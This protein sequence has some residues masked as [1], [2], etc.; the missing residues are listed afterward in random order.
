MEGIHH[1][2]LNLCSVDD[3]QALGNQKL[4]ELTSLDLRHITEL[5]NET[6]M[7]VVKR[8]RNLSSLNLCLN[9]SINDSEANGTGSHMK[10]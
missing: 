1:S 4:K 2:P 3:G 9:W 5:N 8:C 7:E 6:V 10:C